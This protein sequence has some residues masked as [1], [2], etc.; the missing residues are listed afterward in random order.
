[1]AFVWEL[2]KETI[3]LPL[4]CLQ[5]GLPRGRR[6]AWRTWGSGT[7]ASPA[8]PARL[9]G[10]DEDAWVLV[11]DRARARPDAIHDAAVLMPL[12]LMAG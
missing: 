2:T 4:G 9:S 11:S 3:D 6:A 8:L 1:M 10:R 12:R 5:G 7:G